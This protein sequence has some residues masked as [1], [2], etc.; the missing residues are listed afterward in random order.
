LHNICESRRELLN[1]ECIDAAQKYDREFQPSCVANRSNNGT[2][3]DKGKK[4]RNIFVEY[5][6]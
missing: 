2:N 3:C 1:A 4:I 6:D 5:F